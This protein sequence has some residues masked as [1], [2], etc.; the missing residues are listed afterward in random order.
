MASVRETYVLDVLIQFG[1]FPEHVGFELGQT[2]MIFVRVDRE[3]LTA[4]DRCRR[5][6]GHTV[7]ALQPFESSPGSGSDS[8][9]KTRKQRFVRYG[10]KERP[11]RQFGPPDPDLPP[12]PP[13]FHFTTASR[14]VSSRHHA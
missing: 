9:S 2:G 10:C 8:G 3:Y 6:G 12:L 5:A 13:A 7:C 11:V 14:S 1:I 4:G